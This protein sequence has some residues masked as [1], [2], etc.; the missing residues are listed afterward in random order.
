[1][2][3]CYKPGLCLVACLPGYLRRVDGAAARACGAPVAQQGKTCSAPLQ[4]TAACLVEP[5]QAFLHGKNKAALANPSILVT[6]IACTACL[7]RNDTRQFLQALVRQALASGAD[8]GNQTPISQ[9]DHYRTTLQAG[10]RL[11]TVEIRLIVF[12]ALT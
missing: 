5:A 9:L 6:S 10:A 3:A 8:S 2:V 4:D 1:M 7:A 12:P 11:F